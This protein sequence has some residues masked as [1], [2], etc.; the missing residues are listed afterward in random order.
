MCDRANGGGG[1]RIRI[2]VGCHI[3]EVC[4][5]CRAQG[6]AGAIRRAESRSNIRSSRS[7]SIIIIIIRSSG[8]SVVA[9][10]AESYRCERCCC[11]GGF[12]LRYSRAF[13]SC[14]LDGGRQHVGGARHGARH[15]RRHERHCRRRHGHRADRRHGPRDA[16]GVY[17]GVYLGE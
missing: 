6:G 5:G 3:R 1:D 10:A 8:G 14:H 15:E 11:G 12:C 13:G 4:A 17:L 9:V 16:S 2:R 7:S